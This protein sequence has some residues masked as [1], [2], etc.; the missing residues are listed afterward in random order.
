MRDGVAD[1]SLRDADPKETALLLGNWV[2]WTYVHL[3]TAHRLTRKEARSIVLRRV[4]QALT[5]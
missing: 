2:G 1:G 3:R 4:I 5:P